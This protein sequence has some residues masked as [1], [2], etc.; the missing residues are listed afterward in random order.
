MPTKRLGKNTMQFAAPVYLTGYAAVAGQK[1]A[2]GPLTAFFDFA[3][4][5]DTFGQK[6][7]EQ[8]E[9]IMQQKAVELALGKTAIKAADIDYL[10]A[11]D[12]LNQCAASHYGLRELGMKFFGLYGACST[13]AEGL[14]MAAA[15]IDGGFADNCL[16]VTSSHY[17][18]AERQF[19]LPIEFGSQRTPT[20]Q[21]TVTGA[22]AVLAQNAAPVGAPTQLPGE[23][24]ATKQAVITRATVGRMCDMGI[25]DANNMGSAMAPAVVSTLLDFFT[26][27]GTNQNAYDLIVTGDLGRVGADLVLELM[28]REGYDLRPIYNDCGLMIYDCDSQDVHA[29]GSGCGCSAVVLTS[30]ILPRIQSGQ[31]NN[32]LFIGTGALL[33]SNNVLQGDTIPGIAH[34]VHLTGN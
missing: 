9:S 7:W 20:A 21:W 26:D 33:G 30:H 31:L 27:T 5:D 6:S 28:G 14:I 12:L 3:S 4:D 24:L 13:M 2:E 19:R 32:V 16:A 22:G 17:A 15:Y 23:Q 1:E 18:S 8:S 25:T 29:G 10:F 34:L 11:G